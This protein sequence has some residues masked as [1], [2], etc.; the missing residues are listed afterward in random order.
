[1]TH[2][3]FNPLRLRALRRI[4]LTCTSLPAGVEFY[5][6]V[7]GLEVVVDETDRACLRGLGP[8][9]H[10]IELTHGDVPALNHIAFA[11]A[12]PA[13]VDAA[14]EYLTTAGVAIETEPGP[15][16]RPG[17]GY[18]LAFRDLEQRRIVLSAKV[19][20][21][22]PRSLDSDCP[23]QL[24]HIVL[25]SDRFDDT[26]EFWTEVLGLRISDWSE[27]QMAFLRCN[28]THHSI[29]F[30][31][32]DWTS[33]NHVA[34]EVPSVERFLQAVGRLRHAGIE[35]LWGVGRHGPGNNPFAYYGDPVGFVPEVTTALAEVDEAT[36]IPRVWQRVPEQSDM[37]GT[38]GPP[39]AEVRSRMAGQPDPGSL[40]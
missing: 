12:T 9:H 30:N 27:D 40:R 10:I 39:S 11:V 19:A 33:V 7:W 29:A 16:D 36:W 2:A 8:E 31:R 14:A 35:P 13:D 24:S 18:E 23:V 37:W 25:N 38:A 5:R 1:M 20:A 4:S 26:I 28:R 3:S 34:Y 15:V 21:A 32:A 6:D 22:S 17:G